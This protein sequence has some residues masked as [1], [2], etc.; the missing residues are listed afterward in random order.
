MMNREIVVQWLNETDN[1]EPG[2]SLFLICE[3][4]EESRQMVRQFKTELK[5]L[6][7]IDPVKASKITVTTAIRD[8]RY[9]MELKKTFG[10]PLIGFKKGKDGVTSRIELDDPD[11]RRRLLCMKEDGYSLEEVEDLEG[12]LSNDEKKIFG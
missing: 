1:L 4:R 9:W 8:Q 3:N 2:E 12:E 7:H 5:V 6:S 10:S 11:K